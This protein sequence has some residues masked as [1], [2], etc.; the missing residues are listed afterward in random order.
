MVFLTTLL[1]SVFI[2]IALI[3]LFNR[4]CVRVHLIDVPNERKVHSIPV[5]KSG[6]IAMAIGALVP[7]LF[8]THLE[9][10]VK[11]YLMGGA[12]ILLSGLIDDVRGL[13]PRTK[14]AAQVAAAFIAIFPGMV[15]IE[16][17]GGLLGDGLLLPDWISI[18]L[19]I[20]TIV[21]VTNAINLADGLDGLA[22]GISLLTFCCIAFLAYL[23]Q[24]H[25]IALLS[26][27]LAGAIFGFLRF[28]TFPASIF[29]GDTGSQ[30]LGYSA[31]LLSLKLTQGKPALSPLLPLLILGFPVLDTIAVMA[32]RLQEKRPFFLADKNHFHHRLMRL[33]LYQTE[34]VLLIYILQAG[35]ITSALLLRFHSEWLLLIGFITFSVIVTGLFTLANKRAYRLK[36]SDFL[37]RIIKGN[38]RE[39]REKGTIVRV[40][41]RI[42]E[43]GI[44]CLL[45]FTCFLPSDVPQLASYLCLGLIGVLIAVW[46]FWRKNLGLVLRA[47]LYLFIPYAVYAGGMDTVSWM[48][49]KLTS[50]YNISFL[51]LALFIV[52]IMKF[53]RR[54]QGF[55]STPM[56]FLILFI[57]FVVPNLPVVEIQSYRLGLMAAKIVT[58]FF[59]YEVLMGELRREYRKL[60]GFTVVSLGVVLLKG[61]I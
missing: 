34:S 10:F 8:W 43:F 44:P 18:P 11:W 7:V 6:G 56:D 37:D 14:F 24:D 47:S 38:L 49:G 25:M 45:L 5:P 13:G 2:T 21:G 22:G 32:Q 61:F 27:A 15:R 39:L 58:L 23:V 31:I 17:L 16:S 41:F 55:K 33:G 12:I 51:F 3:P 4:V 19:T 36:R 26:I 57:A 59:C 29:M 60:T 52:L 1:F 48:A 20:I 9:D 46:Y 53:S 50:Y 35:L 28:N 40:S 42:I 30:F 54:K